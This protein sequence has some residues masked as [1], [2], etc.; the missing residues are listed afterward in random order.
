MT[1]NALIE[2]LAT[3]RLEQDLSFEELAAQMGDAGY[4]V[5]GRAL[6]LLLTKR[7]RT[8]PRDRTLYK[9]KQFLARTKARRGRREG[10][11]A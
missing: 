9:I 3:Y 4:P 7:L 6:H 1:D 10:R 2:Q 5:R 8:A 11:V